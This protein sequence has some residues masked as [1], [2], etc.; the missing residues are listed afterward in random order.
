MRTRPVRSA[1][2]RR[3]RSAARLLADLV[4]GALLVTR[5]A[6]ALAAA[7]DAPGAN[8]AHAPTAP[9]VPALT[10][11]P[12]ASGGVPSTTGHGATSSDAQP[13]LFS[14]QGPADR[15]VGSRLAARGIYV[16][17]W[18]I[19]EYGGVTAGGLQHG[20]FFT[21]WTLLGANLDMDRIAGVAGAQVHLIADDIS[22]QGQTQEYNGAEWSFLNNWGNHDGLQLREFT[23][24]Q[25]L[26]S[27]HLFILA[28]RSNPK[29][30]EFEGSELYCQF[31]TFLC[32]TPT[33]FNIDGAPSSFTTSTWG[34][35]ILV[36]PTRDTY[37]KGGIWEVE[38]W[39]KATNHN[40]WPGP[41]WGL[42]K[43]EG[44]FIPLEAGYR[45]DLSSD[46]HP[47]RFD[48]GFIYDTSLYDDPIRDQ[49][50]FDR[51][52]HGGAARPRR[53]RTSIYLQ[54]QQMVWSASGDTRGLTLFGAANFLTSG[55]GLARDGI[56][57]G[58]FDSGPF[59]A[60][61][62]DSAGLAVQSFLW[63]RSTVR[64]MNETLN[65]EGYLN[66]W[67]GAETLIE[68]NYGFNLA[69]GIT[70]TP[71]ME[72]IFD[73]DQLGAKRILPGIDHAVQAGLML[74]IELNPALGLPAL[75]RI[76]N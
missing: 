7:A 13:Y 20:S 23:W 45:T 49:Q 10:P 72:Y 18:N 2:R 42:D 16:T 50:G 47:R 6:A 52:I 68:A 26:L 24:D 67:S 62:R 31:A 8:E 15:A 3:R 65:Q 57:A 66:Q 12:D 1:A 69:P 25:A 63:N 76:R 73:P 22:G 44:E 74:D 4:V 27:G 75:H 5:A 17:G 53:G 35:R 11:A 41:D 59:K 19:A 60:R 30:G 61:P 38:P 39:I 14:L 37:I 33:S 32:S 58:L 55:D 21:N 29:G 34:A 48:I 51:P 54:L 56:V 46:R 71:Y 43:A 28:G 40:S 36:K 70:T 9:S 64:S